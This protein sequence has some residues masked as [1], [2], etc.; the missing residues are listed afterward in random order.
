MPNLHLSCQIF[1][2]APQAFRQVSWGF[3]IVTTK[4]TKLCLYLLLPKSIVFQSLRSL[5]KVDFRGKNVVE[6]ELA[7]K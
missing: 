4:L 2:L 3:G 5:G 1:C 7:R 6:T